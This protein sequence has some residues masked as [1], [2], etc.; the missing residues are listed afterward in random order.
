MNKGYWRNTFR[1]V[2]TRNMKYDNRETIILS[3][4]FLVLL[5]KI[6]IYIYIY[7]KQYRK[8]PH[9][10][11]YMHCRC[12]N[13]KVN[14]RAIIFSSLP[15]FYI[16]YYNFKL[17]KKLFLFLYQNYRLVCKIFQTHVSVTID[18]KNDNSRKETYVY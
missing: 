1:K 8:I 2:H 15:F 4:R 7:I 14:I 9:D 11:Q 12:R 10:I 13:I 17:I 16:R 5:E 6:Y 18:K 3:F